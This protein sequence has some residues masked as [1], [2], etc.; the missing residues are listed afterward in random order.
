MD[1][2][3]VYY[4]SKCM[5]QMEA[6]GVCPHCGHSSRRSESRRNCLE[7]GTFLNDR[8]L[9][10]AVIGSGGFGIT[11]AAWDTLLETPVAI[12]EYFP[13]DFAERDVRDGD[14][15]RLR[16]NHETEYRL[17]LRRFMQ[18]ARVLAMFREV[19]GIVNVS[20]CFE[21]NETFYFVMEY[22]RGISLDEYVKQHKVDARRLLTMMR[23][24]IDA[25]DAVH[26]QGILHRDITPK[27]LMV[28]EN[29]NVKLIDFGSARKI[30]REGTSIIVTEHYAPVEQYDN[31]REQ[32]P[33]TDIYSLCAT[34]Y[35]MI[36]GIVPQE[37]LARQ[38]RDEMKPP[39]ALGISLKKS[40]ER[41]L[42]SGLAVEPER[43]I[44]SMAELRSRLY[45]LPLPEEIR[46]RKTF[47]RR[48]STIGAILFAVCALLIINFTTGLPVY[49][50][51]RL[52]LFPDGWHIT[53]CSICEENCVIPESCLGIGVSAVKKDAFADADTLRSVEIP[54]SIKAIEERAF[55][56]CDGLES[57]VVNEGVERIAEHAF[58]QN[59][60]LREV[61]LPQS[62]EYMAPNA[63]NG[64]GDRLR[65]WGQ[66][67][68]YAE[69]YAYTGGDAAARA[70]RENDYAKTE[71]PRLY[72]GEI[73]FLCRD[74]FA[75]EEVAGGVKIIDCVPGPKAVVFPD[76][77]DAKPVV[78]LQ[79]E[80]FSM[81]E[82]VSLRY[83]CL[84][85]DLQALPNLK[86]DTVF[87]DDDLQQAKRYD[88]GSALCEV[89]EY[90]L[91]GSGAEEIVLPEG[92]QVLGTGAFSGS[93]NLRYVK[94]P[95]TLMEI[96]ENAFADT[97]ML[98]EIVL[99]GS[100]T[101]LNAG[102]FKGSGIE[103]II[104]P[105]GITVMPECVFGFC[106][107]LEKVQ[108]SAA[109]CRIEKQ[110]FIDC[111]RMNYLEIPAGLQYI[112]EGAFRG[113]STLQTV[114]FNGECEGLVIDAEAFNA[115]SSMQYMYLPDGTRSIGQ[116]A[117]GGC[118]SLKVIHIPPSVQEIAGDA[119]A[120]CGRDLIISGSAGSVAEMYAI[121]NA[122]AFENESAWIHVEDAVCEADNNGLPVARAVAF[123]PAE[124]GEE[125][126]LASFYEGLPV[127]EMWEA[128]SVPV[129]AK[130]IVMPLLLESF[131]SDEVIACEEMVFR[132]ELEGFAFWLEDYQSVESTG[133]AIGSIMFS[134][135][136][137]ELIILENGFSGTGIRELQL[138]ENLTYVEQEAFAFCPELEKVAFPEE[139]E[140]MAAR[141]F[142]EC[143]SLKAVELPRG[144]IDLCCMF[145][146]CGQL[147][148]VVLPQSVRTLPFCA[149]A[150]CGSLK[151]VWIYAR[152]LEL[153][154][155]AGVTFFHHSLAG[156]YDP[157]YE[158]EYGSDWA[159]SIAH[160]RQAHLPHPFADSPDVTIHGYA[161]SATESLCRELGLNFEP[162]PEK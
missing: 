126:V 24:T 72:T 43:R 51:L 32:G 26:A 30:D 57:I 11:Y 143:P 8:Y 116:Y 151:D 108:L 35:E 33:W 31:M 145:A 156:Y 137:K 48:A 86:Q 60:S 65:I 50:G 17:G 6:E 121:A 55:F 73:P 139:I 142:R 123:E 49:R 85:D 124:A 21:E 127:V 162:I 28:L 81:D 77:I 152:E 117:F 102:A 92:L 52:A 93:R 37:A 97:A 68:S 38:Y 4:C 67:G 59:P 18:E 53:D 62:L 104:I 54:G 70:S 153:D 135:G 64:A 103:S 144:D 112:G 158:A 74:D 44:R 7:E 25:L 115:C 82:Y 79:P 131:V 141:C 75:A 100:M 130:R 10:G 88:L 113:C 47:I 58:A 2:S 12:K 5:L 91:S 46:R 106:A 20:D 42:M 111:Y 89:G 61:H 90:G 134:D 29:G 45:N 22:V 107:D 157:D 101:C 95:D 80:M 148:T 129:K 40:Q 136:S 149:F 27:N 160:T 150:N 66:H 161:G 132:N 41:A 19:P 1:I 105:E 78:A 56:G 87:H 99:P 114:R 76:Y 146:G 16:E 3:G 159:A 83:I 140:S 147:E 39:S 125:A 34:M 120:G 128:T 119:F 118:K 23:S 133:H 69:K 9:L 122:I 63:L 155:S 154:E 109:V 96:H 98:K 94:L 110:A 15:V 84:P 14:E 13:G 138:P 71:D 36:T